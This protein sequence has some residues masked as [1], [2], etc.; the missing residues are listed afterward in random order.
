MYLFKEWEEEQMG[1]KFMEE[2]NFISGERKCW[3]GGGMLKAFPFAAAAFEINLLSRF[4]FFFFFIKRASRI[5]S[6]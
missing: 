6:F 3:R 1:E 2:K 4:F 5:W